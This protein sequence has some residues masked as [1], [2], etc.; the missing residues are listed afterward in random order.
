L[1]HRLHGRPLRRGGQEDET[2]AMHVKFNG[3][4]ILDDVE[5]LHS[6]PGGIAEGPEARGFYLQAHGLPV[7]FRNIWTVEKKPE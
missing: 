1:R 6:T 5:I 4:T 3:V 2:R 7:F